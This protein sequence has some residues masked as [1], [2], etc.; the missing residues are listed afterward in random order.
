MKI[1]LKVYSNDWYLKYNLSYT[2]A[3]DLLSE[4]GVNFII[5]QSKV[6]PMP[7][8]AVKSE[9]PPELM[10]RYLAYDDV[11]FRE[12]LSKNDIEYCEVDPIF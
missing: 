12:A 9:V 1:G 6:L 7:D 5:A 2:Q 3:A 11:K 10:D 4:W 8:T